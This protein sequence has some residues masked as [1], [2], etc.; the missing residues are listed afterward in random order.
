MLLFRLFLF[1]NTFVD[2]MAKQFRICVGDLC[3]SRLPAEEYDGHS[4]CARCIGLDCSLESRCIECQDWNEDK[5]KAFLK[6]RLDLEKSRARKARRRQLR[7][8]QGKL[9]VDGSVITGNQQPVM[10]SGVHS[11]SPSPSTDSNLISLNVSHDLSQSIDS[12]KSVHSQISQHSAHSAHSAANPIRD[13]AITRTEFDMVLSKLSFLT[14]LVTKS[15]PIA[16]PSVDVPS[17]CVTPPLWSGV[18]LYL[19]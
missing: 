10:G 7:K 19:C 3:S 1:L 5:M 13:Q 2:I 6:H 12:V 9:P 18:G 17:D 8:E 11:I 4:K 14:D 15:L 16:R